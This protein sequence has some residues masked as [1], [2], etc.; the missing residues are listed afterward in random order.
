MRRALLRAFAALFAIALIAADPIDALAAFHHADLQTSALGPDQSLDGWSS[1]GEVAGPEPS[2]GAL[3]Q[4]PGPM[5]DGEPHSH[6][7]DN[8]LSA[9]SLE[10][11]AATSVEILSFAAALF[12][13][14][15]IPPTPPPRAPLHLCIPA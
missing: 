7:D 1:A 5:A 12:G 6:V 8:L 11:P 10:A 4:I 14:S 15:D 9:S 2:L 13:R 3:A